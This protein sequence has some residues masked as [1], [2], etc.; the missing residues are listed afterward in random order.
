MRIGNEME[1]QHKPSKYNTIKNKIKKLRS[2]IKL[3]KI[4]N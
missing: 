4:S 3:K 2:K 1:S